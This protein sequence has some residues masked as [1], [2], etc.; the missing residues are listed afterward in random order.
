ML[1]GLMIYESKG[2]VAFLDVLVDVSV[3]K[4]DLCDKVAR[5]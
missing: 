4:G 5:S 2:R 1:Q 3:E